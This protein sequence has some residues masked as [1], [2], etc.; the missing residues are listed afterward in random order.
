MKESIYIKGGIGGCK[1]ISFAYGLAMANKT[2]YLKSTVRN[3][4]ILTLLPEVAPGR[5]TNQPVPCFTKTHGVSQVLKCVGRGFLRGIGTKTPALHYSLNG[6]NN[7]IKYP[8]SFFLFDLTSEKKAGVF[9]I[10][11]PV[12]LSLIVKQEPM[13]A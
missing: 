5:A 12:L 6:C 3:L 13:I 10:P 11:A 8:L 2:S 7:R 9:G 1:K 4:L